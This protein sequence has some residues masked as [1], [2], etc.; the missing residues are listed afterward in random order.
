MADIYDILAG[1]G[2]GEDKQIRKVFGQ[3]SH[4]NEEEKEAMLSWNLTGKTIMH[5]DEW[6]IFFE[7]PTIFLGTPQRIWEVDN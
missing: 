3:P 4:V 1:N 7:C 6:K 2:R 5:V